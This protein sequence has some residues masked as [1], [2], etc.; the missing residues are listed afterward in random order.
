[1]SKIVLGIDI[2]GSG[3]KGAPVDLEKGCLA[4]DRLRIPSPPNAGPEEV[5]EII[6]Q[7]IRH[8]G[9][10][11]ETVGCC[12][13]AAIKHGTVVTAANIS[14]QWLNTDIN[15]LFS[16][17]TGRRF[18]VINDA[19][20]A[21]NALVRFGSPLN[22]QGTVLVITVGTGLGSAL[23]INGILV[24]NTEFGHI[25]LKGRIA[26]KYAADSVRK[27]KELSWKKWGKRFNRYL[28]TMERLLWPDRIVIG[29]GVSKK[30]SNFRRF[31]TV[32]TPLEMALLKNEAGIIGA[33]LHASEQT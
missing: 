8:F 21:G 17:K 10:K 3:I 23:F 6:Q 30:E 1:M 19:D 15:A 27:T 7:I 5:L 13:P 32:Q 24:P 2:G 12:F 11:K 26:E 20:A 9:I 16:E 22:T 25:E 31:L 14:D 29:G 33:A 4:E 18:F 28:L